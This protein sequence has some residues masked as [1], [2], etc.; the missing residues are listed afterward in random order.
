MQNL[1]T[2]SQSRNLTTREVIRELRADLQQL[3]PWDR[4]HVYL[5]IFK[6]RLKRLLARGRLLQQ[7]P[8]VHILIP[9]AIIIIRIAG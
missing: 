1:G 2:T 4:L 8:P 9:A 6:L 3:S 5:F 7:N